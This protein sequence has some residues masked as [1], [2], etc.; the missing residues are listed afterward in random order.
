MPWGACN[1]GSACVN[2]SSM[3]PSG[4]VSDGGHASDSTNWFRLPLATPS[5]TYS[6]SKAS[7]TLWVCAMVR[8]RQPCR[9]KGTA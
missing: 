3:G 4:S 7:G 6:N 5:A 9:T 1:A 8:C 2:H